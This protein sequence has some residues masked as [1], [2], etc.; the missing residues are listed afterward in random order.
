[1]KAKKHKGIIITAITLASVIVLI[2]LLLCIE[3]ISAAAVFNS[4]IKQQED[5][6]DFLKQSPPSAV[7]EQSFCDFELGN[8]SQIP[9]NAVQF[10]ASH[11]S[12][13]QSVKGVST[14]FLR[15]AELFG[16]SRK[17]ELFYTH[18]RLYSQLDLGV[19]S[20]E[21]DISYKKTKGAID[22][23]CQHISH[24]DNASNIPN[25]KM[26]FEEIALWS[27]NNPNHM[28]VTLL[29]ECSE[30]TVLPP[31]KSIKGEALAALDKT[32]AEVFKDRLFT[33]KDAL[34]NCADFDQMRAI[35]WQT[36][37][38]L[39]GKIMVIL[40]PA[41]N[42]EEYI[43]TDKTMQSQSMFP[44]LHSTSIGSELSKYSAIAL[45]NDPIGDN[46]ENTKAIQSLISSNYF[47]RTRTDSYPD[48]PANQVNAA[49]ESGANILSGDFQ[50]RSNIG[51]YDFVTSFNGK[52]MRI[53][54]YFASLS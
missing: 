23:V 18:E 44:A 45:V 54:P 1:M 42:T 51:K 15:L 6:M 16:A 28:P 22:L 26:G 19:R 41:S 35:G 36:L 43:N 12:Y 32:V 4:C 46:G 21:L 40:H 13:K 49:F 31:F 2:L 37:D 48:Y 10:V 34:G 50:P 20:F 47:V 8:D 52:T 29:L 7:N 24:I 33:P 38:N 14:M 5:Y 27:Q 17:D 53:S 30:G 9:L 3:L 39:R 25:L 11:N